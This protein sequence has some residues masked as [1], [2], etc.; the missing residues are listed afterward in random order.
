M[1]IKPFRLI[2]ASELRHLQGCFTERLAIWN[3]NYALTPLSC[4]LS[5]PLKHCTLNNPHA[6]IDETNQPVALCEENN[7]NFINQHVFGRDFDDVSNTLLL[8]LLNQLFNT[9]SLQYQPD[10]RIN[11]YVY[12]GSPSLALTIESITCYLHPQWVINA[13]PQHPITPKPLNLLDDALASEVLPLAVALNPIGLRVSDIMALQVG[14][15]IQTDHPL[16]MPL[17]LQYQKNTLCNV[18]IGRNNQTQTI[19]ITRT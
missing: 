6:F 11:E 2:N 3:E 10:A 16:S 5:Y 12:T 19:Q 18:D 15:V 9:T 13:L 4:Q 8:S 17:L 7:S 1:R 14:D